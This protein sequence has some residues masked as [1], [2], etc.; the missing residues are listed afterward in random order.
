MP[1]PRQSLAGIGPSSSN[2]PRA[3]IAP[4][5]KSLMPGANRMSIAPNNDDRRSR[6]MSMGGRRSSVAPARGA[7][8]TDDPR[9]ITTREFKQRA[10]EKLV[11]YLTNH[12]YDRAIPVKMVQNLEPPTTKDFVQMISFLLKATI[13]NFEFGS[14][15]EEELPNVLKSLGYPFTLTPAALQTGGAPTSWPK[16]LAML[17]WLVS[18]L[19]YF[20]ATSD[21]ADESNNEL[22]DDE[23]G[24]KMF[25]D[26]LQRGYALFLQGT[27]D[28]SE[29]EEQIAFTFETKNASLH[30]DIASLSQANAELSQQHTALTEGETPL[31]HAKRKNGD[32]LAD[33]AKFEKHIANLEEHR[34]KVSE[35]L[36]SEQ[37]AEGEMQAELAALLEEVATHKATVSAQDLTPADVMRMKEEKA[38]KDAELARLASQKDALSKQ[39]WDEEQAIAQ[40]IERIEGKVTS[41]NNCSLRLHLIPGAAKN[42]RGV[43][44]ELRLQKSSLEAAEPDKLLS[45]D[46]QGVLLPGLQYVKGHVTGELASAQDALLESEEAAARR[47]QGAQERAESL[48]ALKEELAKLEAQDKR[49]REEHAEELAKVKAETESLEEQMV[50]A[51]SVTGQKVTDSAAE[52][53]ALQKEYDEFSAQAG[54]T[55]DRIYNQLVSALDMLALHKETVEKQL[56][57]LK[58]HCAAKMDALAPLLDEESAVELA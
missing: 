45:G 20:E 11:N 28:L 36:L 12:G 37:Q 22:F 7:S 2:G 13:P 42:A 47:E 25:L 1:A 57:G 40:A 53:A 31:V 58:Q 14:K 6:G 8:K 26:Y 44:H 3:S 41:A 24:N 18:L 29:L 49:L 39:L 15:F 32:L 10:I 55:R 54:A 4:G 51:R 27:D 30:S 48:A 9:A 23:D 50:V 21:A 43:S 38:H 52:L 16:I 56:A 46:V 17:D 19:A 33:A 35:R 34:T 5:R